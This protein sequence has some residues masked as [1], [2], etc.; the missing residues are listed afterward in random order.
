MSP[1]ATPAA[2]GYGEYGV[3]VLGTLGYPAGAVTPHAPALALAVAPAEATANLRALPRATTSTASSAST[4]PSTR[5]TGTVGH[6]YLALDQAM[7]ADRARQRTWPTAPCSAASPPTRSRS[8]RFPCSR[9]SDF[10]D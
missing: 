7:I 4:T 3:P 5:Q 9:P 10:F 8:G 6:A 2:D 1:S